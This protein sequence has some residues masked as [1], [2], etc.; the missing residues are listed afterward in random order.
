VSI[1][2][3]LVT[4][5]LPASVLFSSGDVQAAKPTTMLNSNTILFIGFMKLLKMKNRFDGYAKPEPI[6][7][8]EWFKLKIPERRNYALGGGGTISG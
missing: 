7:F 5:N 8:F 1:E 3:G 4:G 6:Q 2:S